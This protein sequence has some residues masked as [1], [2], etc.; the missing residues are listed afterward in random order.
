VVIVNSAAWLLAFLLEH[1]APEQISTAV[2][3]ATVLSG[4]MGGALAPTN[5]LRN[6]GLTAFAGIASTVLILSLY[7]PLTGFRAGMAVGGTGT[8][9][10]AILSLT[11]FYALMFLFIFAV[12]S[13][14]SWLGQRRNMHKA[15]HD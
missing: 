7:V 8:S 13:A 12:E 6:A 15:E 9:F 4:A 10:G 11:A 14:A 1:F 5:S 2:A 3:G